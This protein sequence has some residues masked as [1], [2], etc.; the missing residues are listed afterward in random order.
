MLLPAL[1]KARE[2]ARAVSCANQLKQIGLGAVFY[3]QSYDDFIVP[4]YMGG[5]YYWW[6]LLSNIIQPQSGSEESYNYNGPHSPLFHCPSRNGSCYNFL[7]VS[8][9]I[10]NLCN[11][12]NNIRCGNW[13][14]TG[15]AIDCRMYRISKIKTPGTKLHIGDAPVSDAGAVPQTCRFNFG[16][17]SN[18]LAVAINYVPIDI[19]G[20]KTNFLFLD[21]HVASLKRGEIPPLNFDAAGDKSY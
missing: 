4:Y 11:Y 17:F 16:I 8:G 10:P 15:A 20:G 13:T 9:T 3:L 14:T 5:G 1:G 19:H 21:G 6:P 12:A 2:K 18:S 7:G